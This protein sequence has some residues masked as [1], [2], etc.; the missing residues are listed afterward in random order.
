MK[1]RNLLILAGM[2][3]AAISG[4][5]LALPTSTTPDLVV[6]ISGASAQQKPL[7]QL[8]TSFCASGTLTEYQDAP[9]SGSAGKKWRSYYCQI[10]AANPS[11][12]AE[13]PALAGQNVLFNNRAGGGSIW[14]VVPVARQWAVEYLNIFSGNCTSG[15]SGTE[16]CT[17]DA[18]R[19]TGLQAF[20]AGTNGSECPFEIYSDSSQTDIYTT[21]STGTIYSHNGTTAESTVCLKSDGGV[22]DVEPA[23]FSAATNFPGFPD[24]SLTPAEIASM[25]VKS[26]YGVVFG[27]SVDDVTYRS[28]QQIQGLATYADVTDFTNTGADETVTGDIA[29]P[30]LPKSAITSMLTGQLGSLQE[31]D[32][33]IVPPSPAGAGAMVVCRRVVGSGTQA[34]Q[35]AFFMGN[36]C[37]GSASLQMV[38]SPSGPGLIGTQFVVNNSGSGDVEDCQNNAV[39]G[40]TFGAGVAAIGFNAISKD[41][42]SNNYKFVKVSG[43]DPNL[44]NAIDGTYTHWFEQTI[45]WPSSTPAGDTL[46]ALNMIANVSGDASLISLSGVGFLP[47]LNDWETAPNTLRGTRDGNSCKPVTLSD[48]TP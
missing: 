4:S 25:T 47:S 36:P 43:V 48:D 35:N 38:S 20:T 19:A 7:A 6:N 2:A 45:Q 24:G 10:D 46:D 12:L 1:F 34:A 30:S 23:L 32:Q 39:N 44:A 28:L 37:L 17:W 40:T 16:T 26:E 18:D 8:L 5:A 27:F 33:A 3:S 22:S 14:G 15:G 11:V 41:E 29:R 13:A 31:L 21:T 42:L 9:S